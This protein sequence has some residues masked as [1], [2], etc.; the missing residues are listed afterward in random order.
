MGPLLSATNGTMRAERIGISSLPAPQVGPSIAETSSHGPGTEN[1]GVSPEDVNMEDGESLGPGNK[2]NLSGDAMRSADAETAVGIALGPDE[3]GPDGNM[4]MEDGEGRKTVP[5]LEDKGDSSGDATTSADRSVSG[6]EDEGGSRRDVSMGDGESHLESR[7]PALR[8]EENGDSGGD[9]MSADAGISLEPEDEEYSCRD[10]DVTMADAENSVAR[11]PGAMTIELNRNHSAGDELQNPA[12]PVGTRF[13]HR[14]RQTVTNAPVSELLAAPEGGF[15]EDHRNT[16]ARPRKVK[17][18]ESATRQKRDP[19]MRLGLWEI[20]DVD[21]L[22]SCSNAMNLIG[23]DSPFRKTEKLL[24]STSRNSHP[25]SRQ[26]C[27]S[28]PMTEWVWHT[29]LRLVCM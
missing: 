25:K 24:T 5:G 27:Q 26:T 3:G 19:S 7:T 12:E 1:E 15:D 8:P 29:L 21:A 14:L 6:F 10:T 4:G 2:G 9:D 16:P 22:V 20:I 23:A 11:A 13:S 17:K 28:L 18:K